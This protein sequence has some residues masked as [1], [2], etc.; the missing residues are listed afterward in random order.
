MSQSPSPEHRSASPLAP[1]SPAPFA[2]PFPSD[3][4]PIRVDASVLAQQAGLSDPLSPIPTPGLGRFTTGPE[5]EPLD[6]AARSE[7]A[8]VPLADLIDRATAQLM[9]F[10]RAM[11]EAVRVDRA[12]R[13]HTFELS[14][15]VQ[16]AQ[17]VVAD[18][19]QKIEALSRLAETADRAPAIT[20]DLNQLLAQIQTSHES[21]RSYVEEQLTRQRIGFDTRVALHHDA[22]TV[23]LEKSEFDHRARIE[24]HELG[25]TTRI[26]E[27]EAKVSASATD[28]EARAAS[29]AA[30]AARAAEDA[31]RA[32]FQRLEAGLER[33]A[34]QAQ[35]RVGLLIDD[36][37]QRL[38]ELQGAA[39]RVATSATERVE[40]LAA[41]VN[42][43]LGDDPATG[44]PKPGSLNAA[45]QSA[46]MFTQQARTASA[47]LETLTGATDE[48]QSQLRTAL[49]A[50]RQ[51]FASAAE[52]A[53]AALSQT[54]AAV[55]SVS[56]DRSELEALAVHARAHFIQAREADANLARTGEQA[57]MRA[58]ALQ[59]SMEQVTEQSAGV[60]SLA[61]DLSTLLAR[62]DQARTTLRSEIDQQMP[63]SLPDLAAPPAPVEAKRTDPTLPR[64]L[65][66]K[67][68]WPFAPSSAAA[69][70]SATPESKAA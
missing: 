21:I 24:R 31:F 16:A 70:S 12:A 46:M 52:D 9:V 6:Y 23:Q 62:A 2:W 11:E 34:A 27:L 64:P 66:A 10:R 32:E 48:A 47:N 43:I 54:E 19:D 36:A 60:V 51:Q 20:A 39:D 57:Q 37:Q 42:D 1:S 15:Q 61:R 55:R 53:A 41:R 50:M 58:I 44:T 69:P 67:L 8:G 33:Q 65:P 59:R 3:R 38:A 18:C 35:A 28:I 14:A 56:A 49:D 68:A 26:A 13:T 22:I 17:L 63:A 40:A 45:I 25:I 5:G 7:S 29:T 30:L 4:Q